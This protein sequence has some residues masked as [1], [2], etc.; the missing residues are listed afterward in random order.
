MTF[1][2]DESTTAPAFSFARIET[3]ATGSVSRRVKS[4]EPHYVVRPTSSF[5][6]SRFLG[7]SETVPRVC[8]QIDWARVA[9]GASDAS[10]GIVELQLSSSI[11]QKQVAE[12]APRGEEVSRNQAARALVKKWLAEP[13]D[14]QESAALAAFMQAMNEDRLSDRPLYP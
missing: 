13:I 12:K 8:M 9:E 14:N 2:Y 7:P 5:G 10:T 3:A 1:D 6:C 11:Q 4:R